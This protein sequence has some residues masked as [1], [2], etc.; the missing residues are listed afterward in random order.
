[1]VPY[2]GAKWMEAN[3]YVDVPTALAGQTVTF[4]GTCLSNTL[5]SPYSAIAV[6]KEFGPGY[7]WVGMTTADLVDG[8]DFTVTRSIAPGHIT[9]YG[10][11]LTGPDADPATVASLGKVVIA[12][13]NIDPSLSAVASQA[14]VEGQTATFTRH[15]LQAPRP[16]VID[17]CR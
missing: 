16:S 2:S 1:M 9:Q 6:I 11:I 17:G 15:G 8:S 10:F 14:L 12:V 3:F 7:A 13:T 4:T 5:V